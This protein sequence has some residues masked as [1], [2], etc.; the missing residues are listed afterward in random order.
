MYL[1]PAVEVD[2]FMNKKGFNLIE[3]AI[4]LI[5][6]G[7]M[8]T[9]ITAT[10]N[11]ASENVRLKETKNKVEA[12]IEAVT[13][14]AGANNRLPTAS[15]FSG[16]VTSDQDSFSNDLLYIPD[17][18]ITDTN[19]GG[20]CGKNTTNLRT[21]YSGN[22]AMNTAF[23]IISGASNKNIQTGSTI[24]TGVT[25]VNV[26]SGGG[27]IDNYAADGTAVD[28]YDD[29]VKWVTIGELKNLAGCSEN[30]IE[31]INKEIPFGITNKSYTAVLKAVGGSPFTT[32]GN[33]EWCYEG[34]LQAGITADAGGTLTASADC[35]T[36][37]T[38]RRADSFSIS[39]TPTVS[40]ANYITIFVRNNDGNSTDKRFLL[41]IHPETDLGL[42]G[43]GTTADEISFSEDFDLFSAQ[44]N[45]A[46]AVTGNIKYDTIN[47]II[48]LGQTSVSEMNGWGC[49][50]YPQVLNIDGNKIYAHFNFNFDYVQADGFNFAFIDGTADDT[51][52]GGSGDGLGYGP[53][54][55]H[56]LNNGINVDAFAVE[57]DVYRN[58]AKGDRDASHLAIL[59][60]KTPYCG[61]STCFPQPGQ[62]SNYHYT[63]HGNEA[64]Y[65]N[66]CDSVPTFSN[67]KDYELRFE[68]Y[69][70][71]GSDCDYR[72]PGI[73]NY[74]LIKAFFE[75]D[76][77]CTD[78]TEGYNH[79]AAAEL[80][81]CFVLDD[82]L[83]TSKFGFTYATGGA[84][85]ILNIKDFRLRMYAQEP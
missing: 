65:N 30:G 62:A 22:T 79:G 33:Y 32:G 60:G 38:Y 13:A 46:E 5:V 67:H 72:I 44:D 3:M 11:S 71:L 64:C 84:K 49:V 36:G 80:T 34:T 52:C 53:H 29:I 50:W 45:K 16:L 85:M 74:A 23:V 82:D 25:T 47:Q 2:F 70:Q 54:A 73:G 77:D 58:N 18:G 43:T 27:K 8:L 42:G 76:E 15:E 81:R 68:L 19:T 6:L 35:E 1:L 12:A 39:G 75:C 10:L 66:S 78:L 14:F 9:L 83:K 51:T 69:T 59:T 24:V 28:Y 31:I 7:I 20:L 41:T 26:I 61:N 4:A 63:S 21:S 55:A 40:G 37:G 48:T 17:T 56:N 57:V